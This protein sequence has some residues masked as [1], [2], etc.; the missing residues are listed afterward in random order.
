MAELGAGGGTSFPA[1]LDTDSTQESGSVVTSFNQVNDVAAA[2][3][4]IQTELGTDPALGKAT[5]KA[6]LQ[7][8][9]D[10]DGEHTF[11]IPYNFFQDNV[12]ASQSGVALNF[13]GTTVA[14]IEAPWAGSIVGIMVVSNDARTADTLTVDATVNGTVI[15]LQAVLDVTNSTHHSDTQAKDTDSFS[16]GDRIGVKITTGGSWTPVTAD[17]LVMVFVT[18]N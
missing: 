2:A 7:A 16:A 8:E 4:A 1:A 3:I 10:N 14:E 11:K 6:L 12:A 18:F 17:I 13:T 15:G 9:H 5:V